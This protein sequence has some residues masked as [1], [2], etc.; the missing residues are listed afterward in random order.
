MKLNEMILG[1]FDREM[2]NTRK[3][4]ERVPEDKFDW[5]PHKKS[6]SM[7]QLATHISHL[8]TWVIETINSDSFDLS[9]ADGSRDVSPSPVTSCKEILDRF[10]K[11]VSA[12]RQAIAESDD[13]HLLSPWT[14]LNGGHTVFTMPRIAVLR[15]FFMN[16]LIHHRAQLG[17]YLR[18]NDVPVPALY[19]PSADEAAG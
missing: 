15:N 12:A 17:V 10:D 2:A 5:K 7:S 18:M 4:L 3:S 11:D 9:P 16:H 8:P 19:G 1:E 14:L 6:W 13:A